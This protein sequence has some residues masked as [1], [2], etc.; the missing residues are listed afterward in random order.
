MYNHVDLCMNKQEDLKFLS[1]GGDIK[2]VTKHN[3]SFGAWRKI[4]A[5]NTTNETMSIK[6]QWWSQN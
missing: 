2:Y 6:C 3:G 1:H 4:T 5:T